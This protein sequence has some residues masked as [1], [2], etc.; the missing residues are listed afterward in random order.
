MDRGETSA[1]LAE[2]LGML[3]RAE[4]LAREAIEGRE[5]RGEEITDRTPP[6][7]ALRVLQG[8]AARIEQGS[9]A[10]SAR[11]LGLSRGAGDLEWL[12]EEKSLIDLFY[13]I[14]DYWEEHMW[15]GTGP[16]PWG[17]LKVRHVGRP[18]AE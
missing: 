16:E 12:P 11:R 10:P 2:I 7:V 14:D 8:L 17:S 18:S 13:E 5:R 6:A 15:D 4:E 1:A 9:V 3:H